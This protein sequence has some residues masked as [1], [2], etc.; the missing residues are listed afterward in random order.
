MSEV[1][2]SERLAEIMSD[3]AVRLVVSTGAGVSAESGVPTFRS[4]GGLWKT[5]KAE[6]LAT[7][8]AFMRNPDM[9]W[10]WYEFRRAKIREVQPN[11]GHYE[12][13]RWEKRYRNM[14][15]ITQNID[16]LHLRSGSSQPIEL[17]G[18][19][20]ISKC[21]SCG[22]SAGEVG[23]DKDGKI[24]LCSC[25]GMLRPSV[26]WFG[27]ALPRQAIDQA[28]SAAEN[29]EVYF[30]VGTSGVV[31]PAASLAWAAKNAGAYL[32]EINPE[33]TEVSYMF[34]EVVR[35]PSGVALPAI[36]KRI[37]IPRD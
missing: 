34:D 16:C 35:H 23:L 26:V 33:E 9:V 14:V 4:H 37:G 15:L 13:A 36:G 29:A 3:P 20:M 1:T 24:P 18:N 6:D 2:V 11:P 28:W 10:E 19:I 8:E 17:H 30:S 27:E 31:Q 32:V 7:P 25:G 21:F 12:L 5:Y 22:R